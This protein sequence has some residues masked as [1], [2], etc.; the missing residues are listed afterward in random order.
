MAQQAQAGAAWAGAPTDSCGR[1]STCQAAGQFLDAVAV[2]QEH[3]R[4]AGSQA[5]P[6]VPAVQNDELVLGQAIKVLR[7]GG[8][9]NR[10]RTRNAP[11]NLGAGHPYI[12][13]H[14]ALA[15]LFENG[16]Q[17]HWAQVGRRFCLEELGDEMR[18]VVVGHMKNSSLG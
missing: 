6:G 12:D 9:G 11:R 5:A 15:L 17:G 10:Q 8:R 4:C 1:C 7:D 3:Q 13:Q 2:L 14:H 18:R 16:P